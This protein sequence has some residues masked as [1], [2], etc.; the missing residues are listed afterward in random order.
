VN[1]LLARSEKLALNDASGSP[2]NRAAVLEMIADRY[3]Y[4]DNAERAESLLTRALQL[5]EKSPDAALR[6]RLTCKH[7]AASAN[8][9]NSER[10]LRIIYAEAARPDVDPQT[11]AWCLL[12]SAGVHLNEQRSTETLRDA[13][14]GVEKSRQSTNGGTAEAALLGVI[15]YAYSLSGRGVEAERYF[16]QA[17]RK[18]RELGRQHSD[19]ALAV[20]NDSGVAML[21]AGVPRRALELLDET[22]LIEG[23]RGPDIELTATVV[24][25]RGMALQAL[26]RLQQARAAFDLECQLAIGHS[27]EFSEMHCLVGESSLS[28]QMNELDGAQGYL[29]R[30]DQLISKS[31]APTDSPPAR[32]RA[33]MQARLDL[34][35]GK[36]AEARTGFDRVIVDVAHDQ[37]N[38]YAYLGSAMAA[39]AA[40]DAAKAVELARLAMPIAAVLQ[41]NLPHSIQT[42]LV[43]LWLGRA[44]LRAGERVEGRKTLEAAV[45]HLSNTV[46]ADHPY[47]LQARAELRDAQLLTA[48]PASGEQD[49]Q[50]ADR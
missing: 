37:T 50:Y 27:D 5:V 44:L 25:N 39:L 1:E 3:A 43:S 31:E 2:E 8:L 18:Y 11:A 19:G 22:V 46:D 12:K 32:V 23:Q 6:S 13:Q 21:R 10:W 34:A 16:E 41:G 15:G 48:R 49:Q 42:G 24:G 14:L 4:T 9:G 47:L 28:I 33:L 30:L 17:I 29:D 45:A 38:M 20:L 36:L 7:A 40:N 26:G 35:R